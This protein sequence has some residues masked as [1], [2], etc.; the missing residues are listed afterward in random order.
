VGLQIPLA[1]L[2]VAANSLDEESYTTAVL[3]RK[4]HSCKA[5][6]TST[7]P[8]TSRFAVAAIKESM[9]FQSVALKAPVRGS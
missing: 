6:V 3:F 9:L 2:P 7:L 5:R 4:S 8:L 1:I